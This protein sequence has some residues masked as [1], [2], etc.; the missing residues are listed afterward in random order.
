MD[1]ILQ[2]MFSNAFSYRKYC[3]LIPILYNFISEV[4]IDNKAI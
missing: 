1:Y 2:I 3:I 4:S